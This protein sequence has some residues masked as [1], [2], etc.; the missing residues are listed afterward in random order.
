MSR[1]RGD[2]AFLAAAVATVILGGCS[3]SS[4]Q[5]A[6]STLADGCYTG[7]SQPE[8]DGSYGVVSFCVGDQA[9]TQASFVVYDADGTAHDEDYGLG[10]DGQP[11]D[12]TFYQRAQNAIA[13]E[14][15]YVAQFEETGDQE[16]VEMVAGA[17]LSHRLFM[18]AVTAAMESASHDG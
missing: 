11:A 16:Q 4:A 5:L 3:G 12:Q 2:V 7:T 15:E 8:T 10:S 14:Q 6:A 17:S 18:A 1:R 13:A 9:V